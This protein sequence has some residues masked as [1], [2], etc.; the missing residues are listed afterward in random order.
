MMELLW[1]L[2]GVD[3]KI[4]SLWAQG[5]DINEERRSSL[6]D[7]EL[8]DCEKLEGAKPGSKGSA[9]TPLSLL[10]PCGNVR[11]VCRDLTL[12]EKWKTQSSVKFTNV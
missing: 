4:Q 8:G 12:Q 2:M 7:R 10:L 6:K 3:T 11:A 1:R 5:S 9:P